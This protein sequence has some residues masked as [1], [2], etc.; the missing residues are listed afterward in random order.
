MEAAISLP[1]RRP[2]EC[3]TRRR[4][5]RLR[6]IAGG[7]QIPYSDVDNAL[8]LRACS[9]RRTS[10]GS[11]PWLPNGTVLETEVRF[12]AHAGSPSTGRSKSPRNREHA[13]GRA[14]PG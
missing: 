9:A 7:K 5:R 10:C 13:D 8:I 1:Q 4:L 6:D 14:A 11:R 2:P 3:S 12:G